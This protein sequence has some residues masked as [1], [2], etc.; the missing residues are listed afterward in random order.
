MV[1]ENENKAFFEKPR[2]NERVRD[3]EIIISILEQY[4][5]LPLHR[6]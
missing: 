6:G 3:S 5:P 1:G 4:C 2:M